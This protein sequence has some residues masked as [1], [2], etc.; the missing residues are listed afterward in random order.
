MNAEQPHRA[1]RVSAVDAIPLFLM[2]GEGGWRPGAPAQSAFA[3]SMDDCEECATADARR[4]R[5][6]IAMTNHVH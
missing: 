3:E 1:T 4:C 6:L 5:P 2:P